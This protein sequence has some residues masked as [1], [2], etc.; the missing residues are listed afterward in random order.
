ME[1]DRTDQIE[2]IASYAG[3]LESTAI[4][5]RM[6]NAQQKLT[7]CRRPELFHPSVATAAEHVEHVSEIYLSEIERVARELRKTFDR[8]IGE[9]SGG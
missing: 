8:L 7:R 4:Q 5:I 1:I 3:M 6:A 9:E 2:Q